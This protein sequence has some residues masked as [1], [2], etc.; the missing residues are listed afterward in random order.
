MESVLAPFK[1]PKQIIAVESIPRTELGKIR[2][3]LLAALTAIDRS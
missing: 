1:R 2:R 3:D